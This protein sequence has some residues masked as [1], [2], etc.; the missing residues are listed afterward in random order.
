M[1]YLITVIVNFEVNMKIFC[2]RE[3]VRA[4]LEVRYEIW[5]HVAQWFT[6][7]IVIH[8]LSLGCDRINHVASYYRV[9]VALL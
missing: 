8:Q 2:P 6:M 5:K 7:A 4:W 9:L 3:Y 1:H